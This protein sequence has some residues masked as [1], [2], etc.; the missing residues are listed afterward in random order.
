M[1][2]SNAA[3]RHGCTAH[4]RRGTVWPAQPPSCDPTHGWVYPCALQDPVFRRKDRRW[5]PIVFRLPTQLNHF[6]HGSFFLVR[7]SF[8]AFSFFLSLYS[9]A[10]SGVSSHAA[11]LPR[12]FS[13]A[14][15]DAFFCFFVSSIL[16]GL[17][18][19]LVF[20]DFKGPGTPG[21]AYRSG[22]WPFLISWRCIRKLINV[23][24]STGP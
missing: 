2:C 20:V 3:C 15:C 14:V 12:H 21:G 7:F 6:L 4:E 13:T 10:I 8:R 23:T 17:P 11:V 1:R 19:C 24:V 9:A 16:R 5:P 22:V 18:S